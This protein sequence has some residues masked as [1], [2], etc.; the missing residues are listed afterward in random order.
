MY[1]YLKLAKPAKWDSL[2]KFCNMDGGNNK[3]HNVSSLLHYTSLDVAQILLSEALKDERGV[4]KFHAS[5]IQMMND[6]NEGAHI[7]N[8]FFTDSKLKT[9][10][11]ELWNY[12]YKLKT[13]FVLSLI[14]SDKLSKN[15]GHIPMWK[16]Y[17]ADGKGV[18]LRFKYKELYNLCK[19]KGMPLK[20]CNYLTTQEIRT[21]VTK[22]GKKLREVGT[23][24]ELN[25]YFDDL[26][27]V[28]SFIKGAEWQY[29]NEWRILKVIPQDQV[30]KKNT[31]RGVIE[32]S[33]VELSLDALAE[34]CLGPLTSESTLTS[35]KLLCDKVNKKF[36]VDIKISKSN[37][38]IKL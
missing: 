5:H 2:A 14:K 27:K 11:K 18:Y 24:D 21:K 23:Q 9:D 20:C 17:G 12:Y 10:L 7:L 37:L 32:Y 34:I 31:S 16:M 1:N 30:L 38:K 8:R 4:L 22:F 25:M 33:E 13:P 29:E 15:R 36:N 26:L 28:S 6:M 35:M 19:D 3:S